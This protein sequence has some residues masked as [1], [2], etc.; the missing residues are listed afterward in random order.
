ME[1]IN[2]DA[3]KSFDRK[4]VAAMVNYLENRGGR[5]EWSKDG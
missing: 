2:A 5:K 3:G 4:V 1:L